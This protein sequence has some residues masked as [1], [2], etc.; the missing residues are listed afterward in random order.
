MSTTDSIEPA[1]VPAH[2][3]RC[4]QGRPALLVCGTLIA[5]AQAALP[6][7]AQVSAPYD[8]VSIAT[9][10]EADGYGTSH[11][12][13]VD[14]QEK[15]SDSLPGESIDALVERFSQFPTTINPA[16]DGFAAARI[17]MS[18]NVGV[19]ASALI[20]PIG[21]LFAGAEFYS[22]HTNTGTGSYAID[23]GIAL[24]QMEVSL[25]G[26][27]PFYG[28]DQHASV[29]AELSYVVRDAS[30][31]I[32]SEGIAASYGLELQKTGPGAGID[33]AMSEDLQA[34]VLEYAL[35]DVE[36]FSQVD[37]PVLGGVRRL[38]VDPFVS[39]WTSPLIEPDGQLILT[40]LL[41]ALVSTGFNGAEMGGQARIGDPF[42]FSN[43]PLLTLTLADGPGPDPDPDPDNE[44][45]EPGTLALLALP[46][47]GLFGLRLL[48]RS[49][50]ARLAQVGGI[51]A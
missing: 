17:D 11:L 34:V 26:L 41:T 48:R 3:P 46:G 31:N 12:D 51:T 8:F 16:L 14:Q 23:V 29:I 10:L 47:F 43:D 18:G 9:Q 40:L 15:D 45:P 1:S 30:L 7:R 37:T 13:V 44:V 21:E 24:P 49:R 39:E 35:N 4:R 42:N 33:S 28:L 22:I 36:L 19:G 2:V 38:L 25:M 32:T 27:L 6:A 5:L 20:A 50:H